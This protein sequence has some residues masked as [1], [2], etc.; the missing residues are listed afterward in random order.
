MQKVTAIKKEETEMK[1]RMFKIDGC[2]GQGKRMT[3]G[4]RKAGKVMVFRILLA[5]LAV[6]AALAIPV[7]E[8]PRMVSASYNATILENK[9]ENAKITNEDREVAYVFLIEHMDRIRALHDL[10]PEAEQRMQDVMYQANVFIANNDLTVGQL[11]AYVNSTEMDLTAAAAM[12][13]PG[14]QSFLF[15]SNTSEVT[16][17]NYGQPTTLTFGLVNLGQA[18]VTDV[19]ITPTVSNDVSKW[20]FV[21]QTAQD[22]RIIDRIRASTNMAEAQALRREVSWNFVVAGNAKT[23]TYPLPFHLIYY[24]N[25]AIEERDIT[26]YIHI[27]GAPGAGSLIEEDKPKEE[28]GKLSMPRIIVTG[29]TTDPGTVNAGD[30]FLL[31]IT[32][33]NTSA[34]TTVSNIQFDLKAA[35]EGEK[36]EN[37]Y[38]AFLPT[39][40]SATI[41]VRSIAPGESADIQIEM[42]ARGDLTQKPYVITVNAAYEDYKHNPYTASTNVS[43][44]VRQPPRYDTGDAEILPEAVEVGGSANIMFPVYNMGKVTLYNV[45]VAFEGDSISG[46]NTFLGKLEPGATG[47]VDAMVNAV[48]PTMDD[49]TIRAIISFEDESGNVTSF[50]KELNLWVSEPY[51]EEYPEDWEFEDPDAMAEKSGPPK[52][53]IF[54]GIGGGAAIGVIVG[55]IVAVSKKKKRRAAELA[56]LEEDDE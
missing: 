9:D 8:Q 16:F 20:P 37:T 4:F 36:D 35:T 23:G 45:Q 46:G 25:G 34:D 48:A 24:R 41:F 22:A 1:E 18:D 52:W 19:V 6:G 17:A 28:E 44:P 47:N 27:K 51:Y 10:S 13:V 39:S 11:I 14:A 49:G 15:V 31:T 43:I 42:T 3:D 21:I 38:E 30:T 29:F 54:G 12:N 5:A 33:Q 7:P 53:L 55:I 50:E 26:T 32:V 56:A 40:G 2:G